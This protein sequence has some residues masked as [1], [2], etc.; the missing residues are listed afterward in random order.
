MPIA[1]AD[2]FVVMPVVNEF[3]GLLA[4]RNWQMLVPA[5]SDA[6]AS[7]AKDNHGSDRRDESN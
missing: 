2:L 1:W 7:V 3:D 4:V 6:I 5:R